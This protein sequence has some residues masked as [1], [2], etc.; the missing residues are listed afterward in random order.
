MNMN[1]ANKIRESY[2]DTDKDFDK[3]VGLTNMNLSDLL[4]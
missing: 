1:E 3:Y 4:K 2:Q